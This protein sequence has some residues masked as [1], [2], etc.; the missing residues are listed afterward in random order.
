MRRYIQS[1]AGDVTL[2]KFIL[3]PMDMII[4]ILITIL[5]LAFVSVITYIIFNFVYLKKEN[6]DNNYEFNDY[7][8]PCNNVIDTN[9]I[10]VLKETKDLVKGSM[11]LNQMMVETD[12]NIEKMRISI[13]IPQ[14]TNKII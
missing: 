9:S 5:L 6:E 8:F 7:D 4:S 13:V 3:V 14:K 11:R 2:C 12:E 10:D 1:S